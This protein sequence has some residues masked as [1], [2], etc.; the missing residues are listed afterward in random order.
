M[1]QIYKDDQRIM[2][3]EGYLLI[4]EGKRGKKEFS[5]FGIE[6]S[7]TLPQG[8]ALM[9]KKAGENSKNWSTLIVKKVKG[10]G[11]APLCVIP[12]ESKG[13]IQQAIDF[14]EDVSEKIRNNSSNLDRLKVEKLFQKAES[15]IDYLGEYYNALRNAEKALEN[16]KKEYPEQAKKEK[17][18]S[19]IAKAEK[20]EE[21]AKQALVYDSDGWLDEKAQQKR[22]NNFLAQAETSRKEAKNLIRQ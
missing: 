1:K 21:L 5:L 9:L 10:Y 4:I 14:Y 12:N 19:L 2:S 3:T 7:G 15:L 17:Y 13:S 6:I 18:R 16:W 20:Q 8:A 11:G 22:H